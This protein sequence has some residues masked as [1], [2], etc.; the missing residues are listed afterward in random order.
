LF[1]PKHF[2]SAGYSN[3]PYYGGFFGLLREWVKNNIVNVHTLNH[4]LFFDFISSRLT[5]LWEHY[6]D[7]YTEYGSSVYGNVTTSFKTDRGSIRKTYNVRLQYYN[8]EY[9][10]R[11]RLF[12][13]HGSIDS[14][15]LRLQNSDKEFRIKK[16]YGVGEFLMEKFDEQVGK[17]KYEAVFTDTHPDFLSGTTE[18]IRQYNI[19][20]YESL[21]NHFKTNLQKS[22]KLLIIGYG[23]QDKGIND[24]LEMN[25]LVYRKPVVVIDVKKHD[26]ELFKTYENQFQFLLNGVS[27]YDYDELMKIVY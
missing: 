22:S 1:F 25:Y 24:L 3:Y 8:G 13:L 11:L 23:F 2:E 14:Y 17:Y 6:S 15:V 7:G 5:D 26:I 27:N 12:K 21:F 16:D 10:N 4:D 9:E 19:P 20:F 18:K